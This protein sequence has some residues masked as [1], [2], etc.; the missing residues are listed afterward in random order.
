MTKR[1]SLD[2][3]YGRDREI[4]KSLASFDGFLK[5]DYFALFSSDQRSTHAMSFSL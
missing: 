2:K 1:S 5:S 4:E 3:L